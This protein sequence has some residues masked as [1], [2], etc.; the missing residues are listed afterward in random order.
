MQIEKRM[1][2]VAKDEDIEL[3]QGVALLVAFVIVLL[4][5][6]QVEWCVAGLIAK[7]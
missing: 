2:W 6:S 4:W 3:K 7:A 1:G 5:K